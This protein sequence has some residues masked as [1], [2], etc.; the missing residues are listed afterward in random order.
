MMKALCSWFN[1]RTGLG[2]WCCRMAES[3]VPG[4]ACMCKVLPC[5]ITFAFC[6]QAI[7]GFFLWAYYSPSEQTAWE[8]VYFLQHEVLGGWLLRAIHHYS[9]HV[10]IALLILYVVQSILRGAYRAPR[11]LVFWAIVGLGLCAWPPRSL[12]ICSPGIR[13]ATPPPRPAPDSSPSC[14]GWAAACCASPS[15]GRDRRWAIFRSP[16]SSPCTSAC[17]APRS[18][19]CW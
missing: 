16:D 9:A 7:T 8:S 3:P 14:P 10:L 12:A 6:V 15:A 18:C 19:C 1:D 13:T 17:L 2:D 5:T 11:E 4:G